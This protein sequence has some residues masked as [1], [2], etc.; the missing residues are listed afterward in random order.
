MISTDKD[1]RLED[2]ADNLLLQNKSLKKTLTEKDLLIRETNHR[3]KNNLQ[4]IISLINIQANEY[5]SKEVSDFLDKC[6]NKIIALSLIHEELYIKDTL[7]EIDLK[8]YITYLVDNINTSF[9]EKNKNVKTKINITN[10]FI[11]SKIASYIGIIINELFFNAYKH[12]FSNRESGTISIEIIEKK[13]YYQFDFWD[14]GKGICTTSDYEK[15]SGL[16]LVNEL[17]KHINGTITIE[18]KNG[19][20]VTISINKL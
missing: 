15:T 8:N 19:T 2:K 5:I 7:S 3:I 20:Q 16:A 11:D 9:N 12:A 10:I 4:L 14:N 1:I 13:D 18:N 6:R 17:V